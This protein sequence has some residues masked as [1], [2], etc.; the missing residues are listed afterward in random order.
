V[1]ALLSVVVP[2]VN[3]LEDLVG[4]LE[5]LDAQAEDVEMEVLVVDRVGASVQQAVARDFPRARIISVARGTSIPRMRALAFD[6]ATADAVAVI[7][8]HVIVPRG[9]ARALLD[10]Q[11]ETGAVVGGSIDN[12]A[13]SSIIDWAAFF[14]EYS[15]CLAPLPRG[16]A[17]SVPG[18]NVIYQRK[19]S[20]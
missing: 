3:G 18:N 8:D 14:C 16:P 13:R 10:A 15:H 17:S 12:A 4:C 20:R 5:A 2:S 11:G 9:W 6:A 1:S 7:E 19:R